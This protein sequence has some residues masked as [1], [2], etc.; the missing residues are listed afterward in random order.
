MIYMGLRE[1]GWGRFDNTK[2]RITILRTATKRK[3]KMGW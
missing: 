2:S 3:K 1:N